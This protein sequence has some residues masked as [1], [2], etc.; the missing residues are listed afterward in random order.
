[1]VVVFKRID[2]FAPVELPWQAK[3]VTL[4]DDRILVLDAE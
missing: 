4:G 2:P 1:V 3:E